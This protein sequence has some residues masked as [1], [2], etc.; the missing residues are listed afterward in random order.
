MVCYLKVVGEL[1]EGAPHEE[2][3]VDAVHPTRVK[4]DERMPD[5]HRLHRLPFGNEA[6]TRQIH[7]YIRSPLEEPLPGLK[8]PLLKEM[9]AFWLVQVP[10]GNTSSRGHPSPETQVPVKW[11]A[12][13]TRPT[14]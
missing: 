10:S 4:V 13:E 9:S 6:R 8:A 2:R 7:T 3:E 5:R 14:C 12:L 11:C 1:A